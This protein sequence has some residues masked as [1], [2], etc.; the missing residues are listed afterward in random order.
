MPQAP[1]STVRPGP[2]LRRLVWLVRL[3]ALV[4]AAALLALPV[5]FWTDPGWVRDA[6][7]GLAG[8]GE[9]PLVIDERALLFGALA[10]LPGVLLGL[11]ALWWLWRL[12]GEYAAGRVFAPA[13]QRH[14]RGFAAALLAS[15]VVTPLMRSAVGVALTLGN[16]PGQRVLVLS[17]SW[18]DYLSILCGAVLLAVALVMADAVRL[19]EDNEGFV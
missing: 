15:A 1:S 13:A 7:P 5:L 6:A 11:A 8:L 4:G 2:G 14:L 18:N 17:L 19:A 12:F 10:S 3:L 16:P 9:H